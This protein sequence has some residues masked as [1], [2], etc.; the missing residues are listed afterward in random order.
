M[1]SCQVLLDSR[2]FPLAHHMY[3]RKVNRIS[4]RV[5]LRSLPGK[6]TDVVGWALSFFCPYEV[7][8]RL[9]GAGVA[10]V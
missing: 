8:V 10:A 2:R 5:A 6:R 4:A 9:H 7:L 3:S 1:S